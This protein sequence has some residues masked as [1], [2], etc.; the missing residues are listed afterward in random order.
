VSCSP[1]RNAYRDCC[2]KRGGGKTALRKHDRCGHYAKKK[3]RKRRRHDPI[4]AST[5]GEEK[6]KK[7]L[8]F[9]FRREG[10]KSRSRFD[11]EG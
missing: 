6:E 9:L 7:T 4:V 1:E 8:A 5:V 11:V 2:G 10:E 3:K